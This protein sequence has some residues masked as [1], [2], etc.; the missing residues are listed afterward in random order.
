[1][2]DLT[3][4][5]KQGQT[6]PEKIAIG[7][8]DLRIVLTYQQLDRLVKSTMG[9]LSHLGLERGHTVALLADNC[10]EFA[11]A[12]LA[13]TSLGALVAPL[14]PALTLDEVTTRLSALS[15]DALVVPTHLSNRVIDS[16]SAAGSPAVWTMSIEG[17]GD[18]ATVH[19]V[20]G[21]G[22]APKAARPSAPFIQ[23]DDIAILM[24]T[25]GSTGAP[26]AVPWTHRNILDSARNIASWYR[27]SP[28]DATLVIMPLFHGHGLAAGLLATL[29]SGGSVY[30]PSTGSFSAHLFWPDM[31]RIGATWYTA[32]PT[33]HRI[34]LN[35]AAQEYPK[36]SPIVLRFIR[37]C[38]APLDEE[39]VKEI[40]SVFHAPLIS[41][42]GMTETAHQACSNPIPFAGTNKTSS[43][44][45]P[46]GVELRIVADDGSDL[47]AG[48]VGE[49]WVRGST[50][51]SGYLN[52]PEANST[53]FV[54]GWFRSGDLGSRDEDGYLFLTG[55]I[56]ELINRGGEKISPHTIDD[57]L[58]SHAKVLEAAAFGEPDVIYGE[59][60]HVA[61]VL[62]PGML[63]SEEEL[64]DYC[65]LRLNSF[66]VP[67]Q[68]HIV[69]SIPQTTKGSFDR[70]ALAQQFSTPTG[71]TQ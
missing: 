15:A 8:S 18:H 50:V 57:V 38:S 60:I 33:I 47:P 54:N 40:T 22:Q 17:S 25:A 41:A 4:L 14:N 31:A 36:D 6:E 5:L 12:L 39:L 70:R 49:V 28:Q 29:A 44:G 45:L 1:M 37:S 58:T 2:N 65:R 48:A 9:Q 3:E 32:V 21:N 24:F 35:R 46:T 7:T 62:R 11:A 56:K 16:E 67:E 20:N 55:R 19:I 10:L 69:A 42:Y 52:D 66:E 68:I 51:V 61:V 30:F 34:L 13:I 71:A 59:N 43:V 63:A 26:K 53:S 64:R 27:L 23:S